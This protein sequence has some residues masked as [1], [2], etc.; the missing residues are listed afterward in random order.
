MQGLIDRLIIEGNGP[1]N[2]WDSA[3]G[4]LWS[5]VVGSEGML[6][7]KRHALNAQET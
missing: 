5:W 4:L 3:P 2:E 1:E 7:A 6:A